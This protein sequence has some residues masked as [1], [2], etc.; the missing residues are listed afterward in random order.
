MRCVGRGCL[1]FASLVE[2]QMRSVAVLVKLRAATAFA[3]Q[4]PLTLA[5]QGTRC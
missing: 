4:V 1:K 5:L 2:M 3:F